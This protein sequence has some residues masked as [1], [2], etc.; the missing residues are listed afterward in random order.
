[1]EPP[2]AIACKSLH[3]TQRSVFL[4]REPAKTLVELG[5]AAALIELPGAA[6]PGRV[7]G[8]I[9][10]EHQRGTFLAPSGAGFEHGAIGH[11]HLDG[12]IIGMDVGLHDFYL[13]LRPVPT[14]QKRKRG[15]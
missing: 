13:S 8:R 15:A 5:N 6:G 1:M 9:D 3:E 11:L 2:F 14:G 10:F 4:E 12:V 7:R